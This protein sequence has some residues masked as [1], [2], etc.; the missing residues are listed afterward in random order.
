MFK[1]F[2]SYHFYKIVRFFIIHLIKYNP[3]PIIL[4]ISLVLVQ[5]VSV[6]RR[7]FVVRSGPLKT[8][9]LGRFGQGGETHSFTSPP[10][11]IKVACR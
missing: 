4:D 5:Y 6:S 10:F 3:L 1:Y 8:E 11:C 2:L 7:R 9:L